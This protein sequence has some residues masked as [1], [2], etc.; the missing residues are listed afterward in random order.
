MIDRSLEYNRKGNQLCSVG[1]VHAGAWEGWIT[2][3]STAIGGYH[4][5]HFVSGSGED[6]GKRV[7]YW[8]QGLN[9]Q[10]FFVGDVVLERSL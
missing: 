7:T 2:E 8:F 1:G 4:S 10:P 5:Q 6:K 3:C 9:E